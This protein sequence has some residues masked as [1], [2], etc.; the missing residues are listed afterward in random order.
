M[1]CCVLVKVEPSLSDYL[2]CTEDGLSIM[3][4]NEVE[5]DMEVGIPHWD[6]H[7]MFK[8][9]CSVQNKD[10]SLRKSGNLLGYKN[11]E[12]SNINRVIRVNGVDITIIGTYL[13]Y[14]Q[15]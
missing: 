5:Y 10:G 7:F 8:N 15:V 12:Y 3:N 13:G 4:F 1:S 14:L 6:G 9:L 11:L 2:V